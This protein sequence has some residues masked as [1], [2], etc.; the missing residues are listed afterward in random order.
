MP[1]FYCYL[2]PSGFVTTDQPLPDGTFTFVF[3]LSEEQH[4]H[5]ESGAVPFITNGALA[6]NPPLPE[7]PPEPTPP[8]MPAVPESVRSAQLCQVLL[9]EMRTI[10]VN[11]TPVQIS[12]FA[13][14]EGAFA[15]PAAWPNELTRLQAK[16][17]WER[18]L[19]IRRNNPL[20][21]LLATSLQLTDA[22]VDSLFVRAE[23]K[24]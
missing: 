10:T 19:N 18:E 14:I 22:Y 9:E 1:Q 4:A 17:K 15:N 20:V 23:A 11:E 2:A 6:F 12:L 7:P 24:D 21:S 13:V 5:L 16:I 3:D 8:P